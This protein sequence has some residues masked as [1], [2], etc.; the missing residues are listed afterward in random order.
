MYPETEFLGDFGVRTVESVI[1]DQLGLIFRRQEKNDLGIDA[2]IEFLEDQKGTGRLIAVQ[3]KCGETF[4]CEKNE[5]GFIFRGE[6]KHFNYWV[7]HSLPVILAICHPLT[8]EVFW[9]HVTKA[10]SILL[11]KSWKIIIP[12]NQR[13]D[14]KCKSEIKRIA[15]QLQHRDIVELALFKFL[16]EKYEKRIEICPLLLEP[17]DFHLLSYIAKIDGNVHMIGYYYN[18]YKQIDKEAIR[19]YETLYFQ[20]MKAM[21]WDRYDKDAKLLL[22]IISDSIQD[23]TL[24]YDLTTHL[25]TVDCIDYFI[26]EYSGSPYFLLTEI[27]DKGNSIYFY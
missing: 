14:G 7:G 4:F 21:G 15:Y 16:Y 9:V 22:F 26:L 8:K 3:I 1:Y 17:R 13:L 23:L 19:E 25:S 2:Q 11:E 18:Y 5:T 20:N 10:N 24:K 27:D 6:I 12:F